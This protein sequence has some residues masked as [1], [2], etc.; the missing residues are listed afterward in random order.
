MRLLIISGILGT[1]LLILASFS[2]EEEQI[3]I[4]KETP[5]WEALAALGVPMPNH[6]VKKGV[7]GVSIEKG[8][9]LV[10][11][12]VTTSPKGRKVGVQ[13]KFY[14]C[15]SCHNVK[16]E[17]PDLRT[18]DPQARLDYAAEKELPFL[19]GTT[20]YGAVNRLHFYNGDYQKKYAG[21]EGIA[22]AKND[23]RAAIQVCAVECS[24]GRAL[25][26]WEMESVLAYLWSLEFKMNDLGFSNS[27][28]VDL[29]DK[30]KDKS[31]HK[32][33]AKGIQSMYLAYS[34]ATFVEPPSNFKEGYAANGNAVNGK[35]IYDL[36]CMHCHG[37]KRY[38]YFNLNES[39]MTFR[40]LKR[41]F[42]K[43]RSH[44]SSY[45]LIRHGMGPRNGRKAYMPNYTKE[46]MSDQQVEDLKAYIWEAAK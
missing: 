1:V 30:L 33:I 27:D 29:Q 16:K 9:E 46:R 21:V 24:K 7:E 18:S 34:P 11:T 13:S 42:E 36:S 43:H 37:K 5:V 31:N 35:K 28:W 41:N 39:K 2:I 44:F 12:G 26:E 10:L 8:K 17:D 20:L 38:S 19:Q 45:Q 22:E 4:E 14:V 25:K 23:L 40:F 3:T 15:T 32:S 6:V